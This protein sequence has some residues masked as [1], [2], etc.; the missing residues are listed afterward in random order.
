MPHNE[1][2]APFINL[3]GPTNKDMG[4]WGHK[5]LFVNY[6]RIIQ[7]RKHLEAATVSIVRHKI[8]A[9]AFPNHKNNQWRIDVV[10]WDTKI[11]QKQ[12]KEKLQRKKICTQLVW[13]E[14]L[15]LSFQSLGQ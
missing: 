15:S 13:L 5:C 10:S 2:E 4:V 1:K 9:L 8:R 11:A 14:K 6:R 12:D 3:L 7:E